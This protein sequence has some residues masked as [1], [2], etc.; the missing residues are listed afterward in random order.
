VSTTWHGLHKKLNE[1]VDETQVDLQTVKAPIDTWS[2]SLKSEIMDTK[3]DFH[4][5]IENTRNDL[6]EELRLI[7]LGKAQMTKILTGTTR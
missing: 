7:I 4:E 1:K 2:W 5:I 3:K 6:H